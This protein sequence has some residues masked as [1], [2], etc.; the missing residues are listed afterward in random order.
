MNHSA[1]SEKEDNLYCNS[2]VIQNSNILMFSCGTGVTPFYSILTNQAQNSKYNF[3]LQASF[4]NKEDSYLLNN[5]NCSLYMKSENNKI[6]T[7]IVKEIISKHNNPIVLIC[8]TQNYN[9]MI[10]DI[11]EYQQIEYFVF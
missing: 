7:D 5:I 1:R 2:R 4:A 8:G 10:I 3:R 6:N 9:K 11:C